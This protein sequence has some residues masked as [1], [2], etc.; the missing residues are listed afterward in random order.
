MVR[1]RTAG[2]PRALCCVLRREARTPIRQQ[3]ASRRQRL[4]LSADAAAAGG[5]AACAL[6]PSTTALPVP[7]PAPPGARGPWWSVGRRRRIGLRHSHSF[8]CHPHCSRCGIRPLCLPLVGRRWT[9]G[10]P[11][12]SRRSCWS[13]CTGE[14]HRAPVSPGQGTAGPSSDQRAGG[15]LVGRARA[16]DRRHGR[17]RSRAGA[18]V[19]RLRHASRRAATALLWTTS[20]SRTSGWRA[21]TRVFLKY[22]GRHEPAQVAR[23][24]DSEEELQDLV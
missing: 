15:D 1:R 8:L 21:S 3:A 10:L 6:N 13:A 7:P 14:Q 2:S 5:G 4:Y 19:A 11:R 17:A 20:W 23:V 18:R 9:I 12:R 24:A 16:V 22:S